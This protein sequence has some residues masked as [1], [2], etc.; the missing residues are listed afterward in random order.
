M[1]GTF[2]ATCT[3]TSYLCFDL[4]LFVSDAPI[5]T[6][7]QSQVNVVEGERMS[8]VC[9]VSAQPEATIQWTLKGSSANMEFQSFKDKPSL[10]ISNVEQYHSGKI[11]CIATN[12]Y[13]STEAHAQVTVQCK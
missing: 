5:V 10:V 1:I 6:L 2:C 9:R 12:K 13:G 3:V 7:D 4:F 8:L 11:S